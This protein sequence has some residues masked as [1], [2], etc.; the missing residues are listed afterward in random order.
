MESDELTAAVKVFDEIVV[1]AER[2]GNSRLLGDRVREPD[3][4][5][6]A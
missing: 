3:A 1:E 4:A 2:L 6:T 5:S